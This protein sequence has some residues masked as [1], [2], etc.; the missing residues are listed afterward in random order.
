MS[1]EATVRAS[2]QI[3]K[4]EVKYR[5]YPDNFT[6]DVSGEKGPVVGA[7]AV[8]I[9]GVAIDLSELTYPGF[10]RI[11]NQGSYTIIVG[12]LDGAVFHPLADVLIGEH[13]IHRLSEFLG[14]ELDTGTGTATTGTGNSL[15][16]RAIG[17]A[18]Q[19]LLEVFEK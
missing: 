17:G 15:Y 7:L 10:C 18:S 13:Y 19:A 11:R 3:T 5:S 4:G 2:L 6:A 12:I 9:G 16:L 1:D 8:P 14:E